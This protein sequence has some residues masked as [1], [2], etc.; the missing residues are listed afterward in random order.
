M[1]VKF[2]VKEPSSSSDFGILR[3]T[4]VMFVVGILAYYCFKTLVTVV[5]LFGSMFPRTTKVGTTLVVSTKAKNWSRHFALGGY[6]QEIRTDSTNVDHVP[7]QT[8][9]CL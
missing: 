4:M 5:S 9:I 6:E 1:T 2:Q 8:D 7:E 3:I